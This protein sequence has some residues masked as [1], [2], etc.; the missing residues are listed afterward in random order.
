VEGQAASAGRAL[1]AGQPRASG[2]LALHV[3]D[4]MTALLRS[5][6][7]GRRIDLTTTAERPSPV[8]LLALEEWSAG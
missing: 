8:P 7:E 6:E 2:A 4:A 3:L 1:G 5:A